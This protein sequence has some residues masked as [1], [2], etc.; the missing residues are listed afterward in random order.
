MYGHYSPMGRAR[1]AP[2]ICPYC[3]GEIR[4]FESHYSEA[5]AETIVVVLCPH[6]RKILGIVN[7]S[8]ED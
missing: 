6:C 5:Q 8:C 7:H 1:Q 4:S 3:E 2:M